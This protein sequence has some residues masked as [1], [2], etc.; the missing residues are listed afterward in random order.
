MQIEDVYRTEV[1]TC[2]PDT[3]LGEI[4]E[5]MRDADTGLAAVLDGGRFV[6]VISERDLVRA[7]AD[8]DDPLLA[9][10]GDHATTHVLTATLGE[11]LLEVA[12]RMVEHN[13]RHMPVVDSDAELI[14]VVSM[15]DAFAVE[16]FLSEP[17][18]TGDA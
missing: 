13:I 5:S 10:V 16:T 17:G 4:A 9:R 18:P 15:R 3:T 1:T 11:D 14:G 2:T 8:E 6:G 7:M 12:R